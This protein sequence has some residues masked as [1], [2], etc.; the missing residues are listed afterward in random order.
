VLVSLQLD[1]HLLPSV[2]SG[3]LEID[4]KGRVAWLNPAAA[5]LLGTGAASAAARRRE[6]ATTPGGGGTLRDNERRM[7]AVTLRAC[8]GNVS[9]AA[10]VWPSHAER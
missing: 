10:R 4:D 2:M 9:R 1:Q 6:P 5:A 8:G 7:I 3:L